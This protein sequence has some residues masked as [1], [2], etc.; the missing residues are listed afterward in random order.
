MASVEWDATAS[1]M[2]YLRDRLL[3]TSGL[4]LNGTDG[5]FLIEQFS[6]ANNGT[7]WVE[8]VIRIYAD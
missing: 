2:V 5:Q 7:R 3:E 4:I 8:A 1:E 6:I